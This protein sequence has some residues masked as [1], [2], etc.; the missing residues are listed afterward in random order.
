MRASVP[1]AKQPFDGEGRIRRT[2]RGS[3]KRLSRI[4]WRDSTP[5]SVW[6]LFLIILLMILGAFAWV[7]QQ[8][9]NTTQNLPRWQ[10]FQNLTL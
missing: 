7:S 4:S 1:Y 3:R 2:Y 10:T 9:A 5:V 8:K 6:I